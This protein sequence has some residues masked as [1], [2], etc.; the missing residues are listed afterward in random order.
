MA[1][2][3]RRKATS[4]TPRRTTTRRRRR[5]TSMS[6]PGRKT[7]RR[8]RSGGG[9]RRR[10]GL[11]EIFSP[12]SFRDGAM[13]TL[14]GTG[15]GMAANLIDRLGLGEA[16]PLLRG[17]VQIGSAM[18]VSAVFKQDRL[19]AGMAGGYGYTLLDELLGERALSEGDWDDAD[20]ADDDAMSEYPDAL[21]EE[22][23]PMFL[24]ED[25]N[26]YYLEEYDL[27]EDGTMFLAENGIPRMYPDFVQEP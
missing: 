25:G 4:T 23:N 24:A 14:W 22:G 21:D 17:G 13:N 20:Y 16:S 15:G 26:L 6:E 1:K 2:R 12:A 18:L 19:A 10:R 11:S 8:R 7:R 27:A 9:G 3:R 5:S